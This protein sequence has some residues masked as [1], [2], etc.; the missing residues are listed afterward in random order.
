MKADERF[1]DNDEVVFLS[2]SF[3]DDVATVSPR[4]TLRN[5]LPKSGFSWHRFRMKIAV[6]IFSPQTVRS[7]KKCV[8]LLKAY[9][10]AI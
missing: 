1:S 5:L 6:V 7:D 9:V 3:F 4:A 10:A 8:V 2:L